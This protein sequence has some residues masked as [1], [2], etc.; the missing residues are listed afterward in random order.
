MAHPTVHACD[1]FLSSGIVNKIQE[2][3]SK[4]LPVVV[5]QIQEYHHLF[6]G[7]R[8]RKVRQEQM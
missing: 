5:V 3:Y 2:L 1:G 7:Y 8:Y 6:T 4:Y